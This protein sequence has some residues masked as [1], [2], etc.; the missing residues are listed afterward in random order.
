MQCNIG[1]VREAQEAYRTV[2]QLEAKHI[3]AMTNLGTI[4]QDVSIR[5]VPMQDA[6]L[7]SC[8]VC[9]CSMF[10]TLCLSGAI[11]QEFGNEMKA[12]FSAHHWIRM[13][14]ICTCAVSCT[15]EGQLSNN[16]RVLLVQRCNSVSSGW[17]NL[18]YKQWKSHVRCCILLLERIAY[19]FK[20]K[21]AVRV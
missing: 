3:G 1:K 13:H 21:Y 10:S 20:S 11:L 18:I 12:T 9:I 19:S 7:F 14:R 5:D 4:L 15:L 2:I 16:V 8:S 6:C 17:G